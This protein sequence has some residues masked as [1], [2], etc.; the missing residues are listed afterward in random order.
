MLDR[1]RAASGDVRPQSECVRPK[2][3]GANSRSRKNG[4]NLIHIGLQE[5]GSHGDQKRTA[6]VWVNQD[7]FVPDAGQGGAQIG[8]Q[9]EEGFQR[10]SPNFR[11]A[12]RAIGDRDAARGYLDH[13]AAGQC[14][15]Q[16]IDRK[17]EQNDPKRKAR[18]DLHE[19]ERPDRDSLAHALIG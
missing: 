1:D 19:G 5:A 9:S 6:A 7:Q 8:G 16:A 12:E 4:S 18:Y 11:A 15:D 10:R 3:W 2:A 13:A 14:I 17:A